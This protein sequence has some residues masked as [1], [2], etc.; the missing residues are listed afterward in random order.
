MHINLRAIRYSGIQRAFDNAALQLIGHALDPAGMGWRPKRT[1]RKCRPSQRPRQ[2]GQHDKTPTPAHAS[3]STPRRTS[4][5]FSAVHTIP[6]T[7][8]FLQTSAN[9]AQYR[10][11]LAKAIT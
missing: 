6:P 4:L 10:I 9:G 5:R 7:L 2:T 1:F 8:E 3:Q 11:A